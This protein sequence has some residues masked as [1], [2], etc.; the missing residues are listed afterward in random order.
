MKDSQKSIAL[1]PG[2]EVGVGP[3]LMLK[4]LAMI[5]PDPQTRFIW[6]SDRAS[7]ELAAARSLCA[8]EFLNDEQARMGGHSI[9]FFAADFMENCPDKRQALSLKKSVELAVAG[10][11]GAIVTGPIEKSA[12]K[13]LDDGFYPGQT[14]YFARYLAKPHSLPFMAFLGGPFVLSLLSTHCPLKEVSNRLTKNGVL[15]HLK[16]ASL[17]CGLLLKKPATEVKI[18]MLGLNPHAGE[19]GLLGAEEIAVLTPAI[20]AARA[21]GL[22]I[23]G[24]LPADGFFS[25]FHKLPK[26]HIPDLVVATYHDQGLIPYKLLTQGCSVNATLGLATPRLS[27]SHGTATQLVGRQLACAKSTKKAITTAIRLA[28]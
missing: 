25:Y 21:L 13:Y 28:N 20:E 1:T 2:A 17:E 4:A 26:N 22:N 19:G 8:I 5:E 6:C 12:L 16:T 11:I 10:K 3:E 7:L 9:R 15:A 23:E 14:E 18:A 27:P 24:P